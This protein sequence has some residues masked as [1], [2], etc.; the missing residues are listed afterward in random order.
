MFVLLFTLRFTLSEGGPMTARRSKEQ[1]LPLIKIIVVIL[2]ILLLLFLFC[3]TSGLHRK[4][5]DDI[6]TSLD[7]KLYPIARGI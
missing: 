6:V 4:F 2:L 1:R 7:I 3:L 5:I